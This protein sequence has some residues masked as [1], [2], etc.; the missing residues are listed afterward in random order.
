MVKK[1]S[2]IQNYTIDGINLFI[3]GI[4]FWTNWLE[5]IFCVVPTALELHTP[6]LHC[7]IGSAR[8]VIDIVVENVHS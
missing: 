7:N 4:G 8:G 3:S 1:T 5:V 2:V 6:T